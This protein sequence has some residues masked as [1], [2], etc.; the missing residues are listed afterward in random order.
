MVEGAELLSMA[1]DSGAPIESV[2]VAP[3]GRANPS[4]AAVVERVYATGVRIFDLAPGVIERIS[5]TVTPQP[6]VAVVGFVP[7][8][9]SGLAGRIHG[10]GVRRRA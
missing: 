6:I 1:L 7:A 8:G 2:Y 5:D 9:L 3:E 10:R 4:V